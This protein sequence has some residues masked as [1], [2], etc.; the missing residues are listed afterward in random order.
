MELVQLTV[1]SKDFVETQNSR[2]FALDYT[3]LEKIGEGSCGR[4]HRALYNRDKSTWAIKLMKLQPQNESPE[5]LQKRESISRMA[6][7]ELMV[8]QELDHPN[9]VRVLGAYSDE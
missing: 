8:L 2:R 7:N 9:I 1:S 5:E 3:V 6:E 4:V